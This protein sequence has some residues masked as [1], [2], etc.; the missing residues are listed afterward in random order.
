MESC[1]K[2]LSE[3]LTQAKSTNDNLTITLEDTQNQIKVHGDVILL[4]Y[5]FF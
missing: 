3:E 4:Y 2:Q 1:N 5:I